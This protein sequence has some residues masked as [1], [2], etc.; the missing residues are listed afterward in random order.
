MNIYIVRH[1]ETDA[2]KNSILQ[3]IIDMP[4]N[5]NGIKLAKITGQRMKGIKFD[6]C[7]SSSLDRAKQTAQIIL[8]ETENNIPIQ[9]DDRIIEMNLGDWDGKSFSPKNLE[10]PLIGI[11]L[12]S[13]NAFWVGKIKN[14]ESAKEVCVRTQDFLKELATKNY[15]NV[16][17]S[18]H[19]A[20]IRAM[21]NMFYKNKKSFWQKHV[22]YNLEV[23]I[24]ESVNG[25]M[26][27]I[28]EEKIYYDKEDIVDR[29]NL[30]QLNKQK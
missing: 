15:Q 16:L 1:G 13:K 5:D 10:V 14:G 2:N 7:Y 28:E 11:L 18:S 17:V 24:V 19:G 9:I 8:E 27:L 23:N 25:N 3:G 12:F 22:P 4:L 29:Y 6:A 20:A 21:L 26:K 30:K